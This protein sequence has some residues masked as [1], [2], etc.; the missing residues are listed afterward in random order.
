MQGSTEAFYGTLGLLSG[1][2][3]AWLLLRDRSRQAILQARKKADELL[4][5]GEQRLSELKSEL[6]TISS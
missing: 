6:K 5:A 4:A 1:A 2:M 3:A